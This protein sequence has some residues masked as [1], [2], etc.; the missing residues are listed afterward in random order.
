MSQDQGQ[1]GI[2][3]IEP[4]AGPP[5]W[6]TALVEAVP[7]PAALA[8]AEGRVLCANRCLFDAVYSDPAGSECHRPAEDQA[9][10]LLEGCEGLRPLLD[11]AVRM[12]HAVGEVRF[13]SARSDGVSP[14][15]Q[16]H[17]GV[18]APGSGQDTL[19][20]LTF[21]GS[22]SAALLRQELATCENKYREL[23]QASVDLV[24]VMDLDG[25]LTFVNKSWQQHVGYASDEIVGTSGLTLV[26]PECH[27]ACLA[28]LRRAAAGEPVENLQFRAAT[29]NGEHLDVLA[30]LAPIR[31]ARG[32]VVQ[33]IGSGRD[34][35][36]LKRTQEQLA[37]SQ[38]RLRVLFEYA[39]DAYYLSDLMGTFLDGNKAAEELCGYRR[40]E[41][42]GKNFLKLDLLP[43]RQL[44][45]AA[46]YLAKNALGHPVGPVEF[47]LRRG[48]HTHVHVEI[49]TYPVQIEG[50]HV[51][52]GI[53]RDIS[54]RKKAEEALK[55]SEEKFKVIFEEAHEGIAYLD[56]V[57]RVLDVNKKT[58]EILQQTKEETVGKHFIELG[59]LDPGDVPRFMTHF[60]Q[61]LLGTL[62]PLNL[63]IKNKQG[64]TL[65]LECSASVVHKKAGVRGLVILLRDVTE[66]KRAEIQLE[67][68]NRNLQDTVGDLERSNQELRDFA[69]VAAH[70]LKA[71]LRGIATLAE[72][73]SQ[74][75]ADKIDDQ[76]R[77]N[78]ALM[79][80]RVDRMILLI[81]GILRYAEIGH[82][83]R[84]V[85]SIDT[86][87]VVA[88]VIEQIAP[89]AHIEIRVERPLPTVFCERVALTQV[90][91]NLISNAV[92]YID[93]PQGEIRI[94]AA[95][96]DGFWRFTVADNG[97]GIESRHFNRLFQM[98]QTLGSVPRAD[99]TGIGL[100]VVKKIVQ[101]HGG[102]VGVESKPGQGS[103]FFFT[104]PKH[105][106]RM[107]HE[108]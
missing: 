69:H 44:P 34:I 102:Q 36:E 95:E 96:E 42:I 57:G 83:D 61:V 32:H 10:D 67:D 43:R 2:G 26:S 73:I 78:L 6:E 39:P 66:R 88:E 21:D 75:C 106:E 86:G 74:D 31:D 20:L 37:S 101:M 70:D 72:W 51:I 48:D 79:R 53:A 49:R 46:G 77:E 84:L 94:A 19:I 3:Y 76:G 71:P 80:Q 97:V 98:F 18:L 87:Q 5:Q 104:L 65:F 108:K 90:F 29:K 54:D 60:Q 63:S 52:L 58:L 15:I 62:E 105:N 41:L 100:A 38:E 12:G 93:K 9:G 27:P 89:G 103:T 8:T 35:T 28:A 91:Q 50:Q 92:K 14:T 23:V 16:A 40:E 59:I 13:V 17:A 68:L 24:F 22:D 33:V 81:D 25:R 55:E 11:E 7:M 99:S 1:L 85:E 107:M 64:E 4:Q 47:H 45:R 56:D 30:N 82:G